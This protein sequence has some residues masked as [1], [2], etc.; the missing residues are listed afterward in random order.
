MNIAVIFAGGVGSRMKSKL[1]IPK[2]FLEVAGKPIIAHTIQIF[3]DNENIDNIVISIIPS[4]IKKMENIVEKYNFKKVV[5]IV[6]GG[7]TGQLSIF[8]GLKAANKISKSAND[9]VLIH[10][11]VRPLI[12]HDLIVD[13]IESVKKYGSAITTSPAKETFVLVDKDKN[14]EQVIDRKKSFIAKAPQSFVLNDILKVEERAIADKNTDVIDSSTLMAMYGYDLHIVE[15]PYE[16]IKITT[17]DDFFMF[18]A[19][20]DAKASGQINGL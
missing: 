18:N 8:N 6:E 17:P 5:A 14:V 1:G 11:G 20:Y 13:N 16:N 3:E 12:T 10:D 4:G 9:I 19:L 7:I 15:G 2:Q